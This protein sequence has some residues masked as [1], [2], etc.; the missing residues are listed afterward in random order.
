MTIT[1]DQPPR[2][3]GR[4]PKSQAVEG[5]AKTSSY[6]IAVLD[7][8]VGILNTLSSSDGP[9]GLADI[10]KSTGLPKPTVFRILAVLNEHDFVESDPDTNGY[11][12]GFTLVRL[13][14]VRRRQSNMHT[15]AIPVMRQIRNALGE[16]IVLSVRSG[17]S[18]VHIDSLEGTHA[19]RRM[20]D[21]GLHAPLYAGASSKILLAGMTDDELDEYLARVERVQI[22]ENTITNA[23]DLRKEV[24][25]IRERG[26][27]ESRGEFVTGGGAIAVPV[28]DYQGRTVAA[29][30]VLTPQPRYTAEHRKKCIDMMLA[31]GLQISERLG[32]RKDGGKK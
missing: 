12:L 22:Q 5:E 20:A 32:Y 14:D 21:L 2:K 31:G 18:R 15:V 30:D 8:A 4:K 10:A 9:L 16:T 27:A 25:V 24:G 1:N 6:S 11:S 17:D 19:M 28:K 26:Y 29:L 23:D 3:K 7:R 13:A